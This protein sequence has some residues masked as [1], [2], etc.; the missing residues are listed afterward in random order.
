MARPLE[1]PQQGVSI[2][3]QGGMAEHQMSQAIT[4]RLLEV[5]I[6]HLSA[7]EGSS[8][9]TLGVESSEAAWTALVEGPA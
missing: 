3:S 1:E 8:L 2:S 9:G 4:S 5:T 6:F 7:I